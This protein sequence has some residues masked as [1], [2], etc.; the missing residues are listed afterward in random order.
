MLQDVL[1][2]IF[3]NQE[4][5]GVFMFC[6]LRRG[7]FWVP[8]FGKSG[9]PEFGVQKKY[10]NE[11]IKINIYVT[12]NVGKVWTGRKK[13]L[14]APFGAIPGH[15]VHGPEKSK[16]CTKFAYFPWWANGPYS[17]GLGVGS[18]CWLLRIGIVG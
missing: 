8:D 4:T 1:L 13:N 7:Y 2:V 5:A 3:A 17:P 16:K 9:D 6:H 18:R 15:F 14:L 11:I 12:Q 10:K